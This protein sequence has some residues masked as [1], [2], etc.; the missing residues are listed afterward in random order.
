VIGTSEGRL[1]EFRECRPFG[2]EEE[3]ETEADGE[4]LDT[5]MLTVVVRLNDTDEEFKWDEDR[6]LWRVTDN[7]E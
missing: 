5:G 1:H 2:I 3:R 7:D 6:V 4:L